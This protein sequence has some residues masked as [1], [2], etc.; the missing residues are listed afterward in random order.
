MF[1]K[2]L[3]PLYQYSLVDPLAQKLMSWS[4]L[5]PSHI[6]LIG[7]FIGISSAFALSF[8]WMVMGLF[9]LL[10][11]GYFDTLDGTVARHKNLTSQFGT[12]LDIVCDR[13][14]EFSIIVSFYSIH[15]T[16][17]LSLFML[18][19]I[20][21]CVTSF[22]VVGIFSENST[23]KGFYYSPGLIERGEAFFFFGL[24]ICFPSFFPLLAV[25]FSLLVF[26]TTGVRLF[27]C[28][29]HFSSQKAN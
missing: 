3:R 25:V 2:Y 29:Q 7:C 20:L 10:V 17:Y 9:L 19:S 27:Q 12:V 8:G 23:E 21:I 1:E 11:S 13:I 22:L 18:G 6:T 14:V 4:F 15:K 16:G 24:M 28:H 5:H 26:L